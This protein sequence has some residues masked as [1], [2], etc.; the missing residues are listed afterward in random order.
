MFVSGIQAGFGKGGRVASESAVQDR[1][2]QPKV[3]VAPVATSPPQ[4]RHST[5]S[6]KPVLRGSDCYEGGKCVDSSRGNH[7]SLGPTV[8]QDTLGREGR[9]KLQLQEDHPW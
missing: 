8:R 6:A 4:P 9:R 5:P 1:P 3:S 7:V 2:V